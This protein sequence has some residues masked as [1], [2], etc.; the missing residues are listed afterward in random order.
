M[1]TA[2]QKLSLG[3]GYGWIQISDQTPCMAGWRRCLGYFPQITRISAL[4]SMLRYKLLVWKRTFWINFS[5]NR[6]LDFAVKCPSLSIFVERII[7][8]HHFANI[9]P[10]IGKELPCMKRT[11]KCYIKSS[12]V[13]N[14]RNTKIL[15]AR[16]TIAKIISQAYL[17]AQ[18]TYIQ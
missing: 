18:H 13:C 9:T 17:G 2:L 15:V 6:F 4:A 12:A 8:T 3:C 16:N 7:S 5:M 1:L 10:T 11:T 14:R